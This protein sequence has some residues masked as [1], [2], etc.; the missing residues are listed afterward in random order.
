MKKNQRKL[1][2]LL[3]ASLLVISNI[4]YA[5]IAEPNLD[6]SY[7]G[8]TGEQFWGQL[9]PA[10]QLCATGK[11]QSPVDIQKAIPQPGHSLEFHYRPLFINALQRNLSH[12][13]SSDKKITVNH[14]HNLQLNFKPNR[15]D[16]ISDHRER[17]YLRQ[18]HFHTPSENLLNGKIFPLEIHLLHQSSTGNLAVVGIFIKPGQENS[19]LAK[20]LHHLP[21][22]KKWRHGLNGLTINLYKLLPST[23]S[24]YSFSGSLTTPPCSEGVKW[25]VMAE[26]IAA[27]AA[28]ITKLK[29]LIGIENAR[30]AQALND[31][32][33]FYTVMPSIPQTKNR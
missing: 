14:G 17:Y 13:R 28:Q 25:L 10:Y 11:N 15:L 27:S 21:S 16:Y 18:L 23:K 8:N 20:L 24:F 9:N 33:I 2:L 32:K 4:G 30:S 6:W 7:T 5:K 22:I 31:R 19:E 3:I 29:Q 12:L 1:Y 26:P